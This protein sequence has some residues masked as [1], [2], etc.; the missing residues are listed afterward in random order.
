MYGVWHKR[1]TGM[2][3]QYRCTPVGDDHRDGQKIVIETRSMMTIGNLSCFTIQLDYQQP[4]LGE[5]V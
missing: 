2:T 1:I 3:E 5:F 4:N